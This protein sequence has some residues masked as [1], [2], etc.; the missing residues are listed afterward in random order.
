MLRAPT[1]V[2][3]PSSSTTLP[4][5]PHTLTPTERKALKARAHALDPV[6]LVGDAGLTPPVMA[7]ID[8]GLTAHELIKVRIFGDDRDARLAMRD[9]IV[10]ELSA[11]PIQ[12]IG[13]LL[14]LFRAAP[15]PESTALPRPSAPGRASAKTNA[16]A[17]RRPLSKVSTRKATAHPRPPRTER[18]RKSGQRSAKKPH[19]GR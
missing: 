7:E 14:V 13:K 12:T 6:V 8:R 5:M 15:L 4:I 3:N 11:E 17:A 10:N 1:R 19:Q 9:R 16:R 18:V 2:A